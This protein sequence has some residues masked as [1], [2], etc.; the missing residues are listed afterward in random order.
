VPGRLNR[1]RIAT[2]HTIIEIPWESRELLLREIGTLASTAGIVEAFEAVDAS[3]PVML[4]AA[5]RDH[6][7]ALITD[8]GGR[9]KPTNLP[10]GI[11]SLRSALAY[12]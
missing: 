12:D 5:Q 4:G 7:H 9:V 2:R 8:W 10:A 3:Q 1:V 11:W 6:L